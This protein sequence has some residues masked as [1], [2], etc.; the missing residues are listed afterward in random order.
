MTLDNDQSTGL[1]ARAAVQASCGWL[2]AATEAAQE[3]DDA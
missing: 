2:S 1:R 3:G